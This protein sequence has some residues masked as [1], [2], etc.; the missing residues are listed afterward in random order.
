MSSSG[1]WLRTSVIY[2]LMALAIILI[3]VLFF[4]PASDTNTVTV[5]TILSDIKTDI[6]KGQQDTLSVS[7]DTITLTR[8]SNTTKEA[9]D[10]NSTFDVTQVL[11][12]NSI[13]YT[14]SKLLVLQYDA[15]SALG[16]WLGVLVNLIPFLLIGGL[17]FFMMRQAQGSNNQAIS[18]RPARRRRAPHR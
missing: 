14:N 4:H 15:P 7:S 16:A 17:L 9:A 12:D 3:I 11:K 2:L 6:S 5:S 10:I 8:G 18:I 13:D 1:R